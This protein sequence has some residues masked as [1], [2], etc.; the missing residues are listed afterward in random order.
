MLKFQTFKAEKHF[1]KF[2]PS[3]KFLKNKPMYE[4]I[5]KI[6]IKSIL[7][8]KLYNYKEKNCFFFSSPCDFE[9]V[10]ELNDLGVELF[11]VT[12]FV[13]TDLKLIKYIASKKKP[14]ILS[15]GLAT[16]NDIKKQLMY[17][18]VKIIKSFY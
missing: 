17:K 9:A 3:F 11:K 18:S 1:L 14:I 7:A 8:Q 5:K 12:S 16:I 6:E 10:D 4:L 15:T 2:A 13:I